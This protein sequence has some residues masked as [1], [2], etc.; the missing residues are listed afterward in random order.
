MKNSKIGVFQLDIFMSTKL[1]DS[2][3]SINNISVYN[4]MCIEHFHSFKFLELNWQVG[5]PK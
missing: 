5:F 2:Y 3:T 4:H 1:K